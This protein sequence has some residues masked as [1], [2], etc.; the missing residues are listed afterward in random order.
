MLS[1]K[2]MREAAKELNR[3][4]D[5]NPPI[6]PS[7]S[8]KELK[9]E[10]LD[11]IRFI[12]PTDVFTPKTQGVID[13]LSG[14]TRETHRAEPVKESTYYEIPP[15]DDEITKEGEEDVVITPE[16][17]VFK[18]PVSAAKKKHSKPV[19]RKPR[20]AKS[21]YVHTGSLAEFMDKIVR[22]GGTWEELTAACVIECKNRKIERPFTEGRIKSH[23]KFRLARNPKYFEGMI[24]DETGVS[25]E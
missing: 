7:I 16:T 8:L 9:E 20:D 15:D 1:E 19:I 25:Q 12:Q 18:G 17:R 10:L 3:V 4:I 24:I 23:V 6:D 22:D 11:G 5:L 21:G 13:E 2:E 14:K